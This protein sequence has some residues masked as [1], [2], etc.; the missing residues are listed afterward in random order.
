M[1][2][3]PLPQGQYRITQK[4]GERPEYYKKYLLNGVPMAGHNGIDLAPAKPG[5]TDQK[6]YAPHEGYVKVIYS[7]DGYGKHVKITSM[8]YDREGWSRQS[9]LAHFND[10]FVNDGAFVHAGDVI[11]IMGKTGDADGIHTHWTYKRLLN[12]KV[13]DYN[14][15]YGGAIDIL[16]NTLVW[17]KP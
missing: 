3:M 17:I 15:G 13:W 2:L 6:I 16:S 4:F 14:N 10:I 9:T 7:Q 1:M 12:G 8:P 11:G 5:Q